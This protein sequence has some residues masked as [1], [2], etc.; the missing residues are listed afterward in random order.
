MTVTETEAPPAAG[1]SAPL[2]EPP[3][4]ATGLAVVLGSGEHRTIGRLW[5]FTS[6]AYLLVAGI[7]GALVGVEKIDTDGLGDVLDEGVLGE[8]LSLHGVAGTFLFLLPLFIGLATHVVPAQVGARSEEHTS[9]LQ[10]L[11]RLPYAVFCLKKKITQ[12]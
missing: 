7:A 4:P 12:I 6:F 8:T 2:L 3:P 10:S 11:M 5:I 9:E 1:T